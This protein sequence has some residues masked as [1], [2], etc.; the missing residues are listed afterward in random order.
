MTTGT[1]LLLAA[2]TISSFNDEGFIPE[3]A[4]SSLNNYQVPVEQISS[5]NADW[6]PPNTG[7]HSEKDP[8]DVPG[9]PAEDD[10]EP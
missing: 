1:I 4:P 7:I 5:L 6:V 3:S 9:L 10:E 2:A 8:V